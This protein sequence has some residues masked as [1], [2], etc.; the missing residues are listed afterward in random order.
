MGKIFVNNVV[1]IGNN[2]VIPGLTTKFKKG[3]SFTL[4]GPSGVA[5]H[6]ASHDCRVQLNEGGDIFL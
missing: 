1:K 2:T 3:D 5:N 6:T 4:L